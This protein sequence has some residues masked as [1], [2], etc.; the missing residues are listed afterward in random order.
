MLVL[1]LNSCGLTKRVYLIEDRRI[2]VAPAGYTNK[3]YNSVSPEEKKALRK[4]NSRRFVAI[5]VGVNALVFVPL[6]L[7]GN[8][9]PNH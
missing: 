8:E 3:T 4:R 5:I 2:A 6:L 1:A 7:G 9:T